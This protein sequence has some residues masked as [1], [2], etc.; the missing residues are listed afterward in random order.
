MGNNANPFAILTKNKDILLPLTMM[1]VIVI[2][3]IPIPAFIMD[4]LL[5]I[6]IMT[7]CDGVFCVDLFEASVGF[8]GF[9]LA[10]VDDYAVPAVAEYC[11]DTADFA[12]WSPGT[13]GCRKYYSVLWRFCR[14]RRNY[15]VGIIVFIILVIINFVVITKGSRSRVGSF[16]AFYFGCDARQADGNRCRFEQW[17]D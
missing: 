10:P 4:F 9:P 16:G 11:F 14:R 15:V 8:L 3:I 5:A 7:G 2:M 13:D 17:F 12:E 1:G 6:S